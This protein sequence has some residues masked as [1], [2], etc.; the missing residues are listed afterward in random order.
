[1]KG[2][3]AEVDV[4]DWARMSFCR[5]EQSTALLIGEDP[6]AIVDGAGLADSCPVETR[7]R[8]HKMFRLLDSHVRM[9]GIG[10][11]QP[12]TDIIEWAVHA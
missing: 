6:Y 11:S 5:I 3:P 7:D 10:F 8:H 9:S 2:S 1:M 12:P 4:T